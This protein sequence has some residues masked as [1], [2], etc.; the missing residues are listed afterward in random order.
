VAKGKE[1]GYGDAD[2]VPLEIYAKAPDQRVEIVHTGSGDR[3]TTFDGRNG[4]MVVPGAY[5]P[6]PNRVLKGAELDGRRLDAMLSF[7]GQIRQSLTNWK[8]AFPTTLGDKDI[9][10]IQG[11]EPSGFPVKLFF[12][13]ETGLL[14]REIRYIEAGLGRA[15]WQT[16]Y[17][18]YR[19]V[20]GVKMPFKWTLYWQ[21]GKNEV[22]LDSIQ[23]NVSIDPARFSRPA[24]GK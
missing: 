23:P 15:T 19:D 12:D 11:T 1:L 4:Y 9:S 21:S 16:D 22:E 8:G 20:A 18:D 5:T 13:D 10:V 6:L 3:T 24:P 2:P 17:S 14:V 7:P